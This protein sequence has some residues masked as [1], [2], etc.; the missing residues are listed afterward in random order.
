M[1]P[2]TWPFELTLIKD[3]A[4]VLRAVS[5]EAEGKGTIPVESRAPRHN[6]H[7][8]SVRPVCLIFFSFLFRSHQ[9]FHFVRCCLFRLS[10]ALRPS[11]FELK[12]KA[13]VTSRAPYRGI[14][15]RVRSYSAILSIRLSLHRPTFPLPR[16]LPSPSTNSQTHPLAHLLTLTHSLT[17]FPPIALQPEAH[18]GH[19]RHC[20][21]PGTKPIRIRAQ[22]SLLFLGCS[23]Q[24]VLFYF[25]G[26]SRARWSF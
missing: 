26:P 15:I 25:H 10:V 5:S 14:A 18:Q 24:L 21:L 6:T 17:L 1:V 11:D 3:Q 4:Q 19:I 23:P 2:V 12:G 13:S 20:C 8:A 7:P 22:G 9:H 16:C